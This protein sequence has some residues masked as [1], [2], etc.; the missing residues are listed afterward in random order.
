[1]SGLLGTFSFLEIISNLLSLF[2][3]YRAMQLAIQIFR[4]RTQLL[5]SPL[6]RYKKQIAEQ[7]SFFIAV[8][9]GV[10]IHEL[11][12]A[13]AVWLFGGQVVEFAYRV[14]WGYVL[15]DRVFPAPQEWFVSV[16]GTLGSLLFGL[17][18]WLGLRRHSAA[19]VRYFARRAFRFQV[20]FS[21]IYYPLFTLVLPIGDWRTIYDFSATPILSGATA[22]FHAGL[23]LLFWYADRIGWF[24]APS[25]ASE[26]AEQQFQRLEQA[27]AQN[28]NHAANQLAYIDRLRQGGA[29]RTAHRQLEQFLAD[30]PHSAEGHLQLAALQGEN[31]GDISPQAKNN[32]QNA[33]S[34]GLAQ[35]QQKAAAYQII[36][37]FYLSS[38]Q[39]KL[40]EEQFS[41]A[42]T[43]VSQLSENLAN[44]RLRAHLL[45]LRSQAYRRERQFEHAVADLNE[46]IKI[47]RQTQNEQ[48]LLFYQSEKESLTA[49]A[50]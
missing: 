36:G 45:H 26:A 3:A 7:A 9:P 13:V 8:P 50:P 32:A 44:P 23:L 18:L 48:A 17:V 27:V 14:F 20:Y 25:H 12:H 6:T 37:R 30:N 28:P 29:T 31:R 21:L 49:I 19:S 5:A 34:L 22:V 10:L 16:A 33:L 4:Q 41:E 42:L 46:A 40:A 15:P 2:Y 43:A 1:M 47:A 39:G 11:G 35:P 24:E 38:G